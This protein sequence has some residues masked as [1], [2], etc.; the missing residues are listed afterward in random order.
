MLPVAHEFSLGGV[1][2]SPSLVA[3][4]LGFLAAL[5]T[6]RALNHFR[7]SKYFFYPPLVMLALVVIYG[8]LIGVFFIG[9]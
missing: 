9:V 1:Y 3:A 4:F 6:A 2:L 5:A 7:L 8:L